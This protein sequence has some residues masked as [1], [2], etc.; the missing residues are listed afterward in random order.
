[1]WRGLGRGGI[2]LPATLAQ[3]LGAN[4]ISPVRGWAAGERLFEALQGHL[5][6]VQHAQLPALVFL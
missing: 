4:L 1:M 3:S 5:Q 6:P 2:V